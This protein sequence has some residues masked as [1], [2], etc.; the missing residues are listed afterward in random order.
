MANWTETWKPQYTY[1]TA[2]Q[3]NTLVSTFEN[4]SEQ[5]RAKRTVS[6]AQFDVV[7]NGLAVATAHSIRAF[8]EAR[9]GAYDTFAFPSYGEVITGSRL[10]CVEG[11]ASKDTITDSSSGFV[12]IG[13]DA[14]HGIWIAGSGA[15]NNGNYTVDS[16][17]AGTVTLDADQDI[18]NESA[19]ASLT[20]Y[21]SYT[22]RFVEDSLDVLWIT[23]SV[24]SLSFSLIEVI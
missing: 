11:G 4:G 1:K 7:F 19:N 16:V 15:S 14:S 23:P 9:Y 17:A 24:C 18:A 13:F 10:A 12:N 5:R 3:W 20:V 8:Y 22:V 21:K 2:K 6:R